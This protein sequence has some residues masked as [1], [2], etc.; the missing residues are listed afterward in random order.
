MRLHGKTALVAGGSG[1]IELATTRLF[2]A[3][4]G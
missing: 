4:G 3:E 2:S 1:G